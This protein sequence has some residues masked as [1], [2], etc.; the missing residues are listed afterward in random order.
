M[1]RSA[2]VARP[3]PIYRNQ[4]LG[5][6]AP[7]DLA[8]IGPKLEFKEFGL[9]HNI[10]EPNRPIRHVYFMER[11]FASLVA[12]GIGANREVEVGLIG[13]E[14][15]TGTPLLHGSDRSP[16]RTYTQA[17]GAA[18]RMSAPNF[19]AM[20]AENSAFRSLMLKFAHVLMVQ[21]AQ[22]ALA[23]GRATL[24]ERLARWILMAQDRINGDALSLTHEFLSIMLGVR[25]SG[26]TVALSALESRGLVTTARG[27]V[28]VADRKS[29]E[30]VAGR[31]YGA[32]EA[33]Y[34]RLIGATSRAG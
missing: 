1:G 23:N 33:E 16:H 27:T 3:A 26:V 11:G 18:Y 19:I 2:A 12:N 30:E 22:T 31:S 5:S 7:Q 24:E 20:A 29:L 14:G 17:A 10:E 32:T 28:V 34:R 6:L 9:R 21:T 15:V 8:L 4:L 13:R 25:R